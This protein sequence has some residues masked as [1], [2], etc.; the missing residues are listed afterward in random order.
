MWNRFGAVLCILLV[1]AATATA[2]PFTIST[3]TPAAR[4]YQDGMAALRQGRLADAERAFKESLTLEPRS[5]APMVG[6]AQVALQKGDQSSA[7]SYL[8]QAL[9]S[10]PESA[11]LQ[12]VWGGFLYSRGDFKQAEAALLKAVSLEPK[13]AGSQASLGDLYLNAFQQP[14]KAV[15]AYRAAVKVDPRHAG[16][17]YG[18]GVALV[19]QG[20]ANEGRDQLLEASKLAPQNPLPYYALGSVHAAQGRHSEA[21]ASLERAIKL[22]PRFPAAQLERGN[23]LMAMNADDRALR[24]FS[25]LPNAPEAQVSIGMI[26]QRHGRWAEAEQAYLAAVRIEPRAAIAY[27]NL[28][29][30]AADRKV[31]LMKALEWAQKAVALDPKVPEFQ[32]TLGWVYRA[33]GNLEKA[34]QTLRAAA[35]VKP[36]RPAVVFTLARV[37]IERGKTALGASE[38]KRALAL[39]PQFPGADLARKQ[40]KDLGQS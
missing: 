10:A 27:N 20:Q 32:G 28:A 37:Y 4:K 22:Q 21:L 36:S 11:Q 29:W 25:E 17:H 31:N 35:D 39:D 12:A 30:M 16:A 18:L 23:V 26:H 40:L 15:E 7:N 19:L 14:A 34:E 8:K 2:D 38:I 5:S 9:A 1:L 6:L 24:A 3:S 33:Q 13:A